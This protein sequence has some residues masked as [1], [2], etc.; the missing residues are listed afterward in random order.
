M[1]ASP[2]TKGRSIQRGNRNLLDLAAYVERRQ[3][4]IPK[5]GYNQ[6]VLMHNSLECGAPACLVG[7]AIHRGDLPGFHAINS[8]IDSPIVTRKYAL[9]YQEAMELFA[10]TGCDSAGNDWRKAVAYVRNFVARRST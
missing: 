6:R 3:R 1:T 7:H 8:G 5:W 9:T 2:P 10:T 4:A